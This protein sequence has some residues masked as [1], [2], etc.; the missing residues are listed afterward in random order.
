MDS[1]KKFL[2][3]QIIVKL[4]EDLVENSY[5]HQWSQNVPFSRSEN[6]PYSFIEANSNVSCSNYTNL[7]CTEWFDLDIPELLECQE[8]IDLN[9]T[10]AN[11]TCANFTVKGRGKGRKFLNDLNCTELIDLDIPELLECPEFIDLNCTNATYTC[12]NF[13]DLNCTEW[14]DLNVEE[15]LEC[16]QYI[17]LNCN[18]TMVNDL[19]ITDTNIDTLHDE[20][21]AVRLNFEIKFPM[22]TTFTSELAD[23]NSVQYKNAA[24]GIENGIRPGLENTAQS[25]RL[26]NYNCK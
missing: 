16:P 4:F 7:N 13:T 19:N 8:F 17:D 9:C 12:A 3:F 6:I 15:L 24:E 25:Y 1:R 18:S 10:Y 26:K 21:N 14:L 22:T 2:N 23:K 11:F 20:I 5:N